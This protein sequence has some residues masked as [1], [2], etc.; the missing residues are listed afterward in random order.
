MTL[1]RELEWDV[2]D[3]AAAVTRNKVTEAK[4][5]V[6]SGDKAPRI[7]GIIYDVE[8]ENCVPGKSDKKDPRFKYCAGWHDHKGMGLAVICAYDLWTLQPRVFCKGNF[9]DFQALILERQEI[10]GFNSLLFD[11]KVVTA[12]GIKITST[13]DILAEARMAAREPK[14]WERGVSKG[15]FS[16]KQLSEDNKLGLLKG[17]Q[18]HLAPQLWQ[19]GQI[20]KVIDYCL[21]DILLTYRLFKKRH[22]LYVASYDKTLDLRE[23]SSLAEFDKK[24]RELIKQAAR[25]D[26]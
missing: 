25:E 21:N 6:I 7:N 20:G 1:E 15:G 24:R 2:N 17:D 14:V 22:N 18:G 9:G 4:A 10:I 8:I 11:D 3:V 19:A 26:W 12:H 23:V 13:Y 5:Q 16:L